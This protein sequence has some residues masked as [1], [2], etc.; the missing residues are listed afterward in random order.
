[1]VQDYTHHN[2]RASPYL[3]ARPAQHADRRA[4]H[5]I[6]TTPPN[7]QT[8]ARNRP[9]TRQAN[10][11]NTF[12]EFADNKRVVEKFERVVEIG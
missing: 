3:I 9:K 11:I 6:A 10:G 7:C 2:R 4:L 1:M 8:T 5:A 12:E